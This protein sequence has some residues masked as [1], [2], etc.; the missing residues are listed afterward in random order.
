MKPKIVFVATE[1]SEAEYFRAALPGDFFDTVFCDNL[2][3]VPKDAN[4]LS[5][6]VNIPVKAEQLQ[7]MPNL[8]MIA[9]RSTGFDNIDL[10]VARQRGII[11]ANTPGYGSAS[12]AEYTF[13]LILALSRKFPEI[14]HE[15]Y[16]SEPN[17]LLERGFDLRDKTI[18]IIGLGAIGGS[19][20]R[21]AHGFGMRILVF[22][23]KKD[24]ELAQQLNLTYVDNIDNLLGES[25]IVTLH[26]PYRKENH[27]FINAEK[28][29][30]MKKNALLINTA[31]GGIVDTVALVRALKMKRLGGAALDVIESEYLIDPDDLIDLA[32]QQDNAAKSTIR[33]ALA[34]LAL[35]R[36][37]NV[38]IT[39]HNAYNTT[40]AIDRINYMT[41]E[42]IFGFYRGEKVYKVD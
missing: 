15:T 13:T 9:C 42:N 36:M 28:L 10:E 20:A 21:I 27:H 31:R 25:D 22:A 18:G 19:V 30:L 6:T 1:P 32:T 8:K 5:V 16:A 38:I 33:H 14:L 29:D 2:K 23:H 4:V 40:E 24:M 3:D 41:L 34:L 39:N 26:I 37:P 12:V 7:A 35:E 11:V 17:R